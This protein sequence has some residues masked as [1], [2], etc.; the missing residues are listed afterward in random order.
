MA[1]NQSETGRDIYGANEE[2]TFFNTPTLLDKSLP[3]F[4]V[5]TLKLLDLRLV[6]KL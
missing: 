6:K 3:A 1:S 2:Y 5:L 4:R